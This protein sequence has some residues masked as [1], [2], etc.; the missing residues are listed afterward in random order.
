MRGFAFFRRPGPE[1]LVLLFSILLFHPIAQADPGVRMAWVHN[2]GP[3]RGVALE[4]GSAGDLYVAG[5]GLGYPATGNGS[6]YATIHYDTSGQVLWTRRYEGPDSLSEEVHS[7]ALDASG[8]VYLTGAIDWTSGPNSICCGNYGTVKYGP[9]GELLWAR[10]YDGALH[11]HDVAVALDVDAAGNVYVTGMVDGICNML[12]C[13][14]GQAATLKYDSAGQLIWMR[15]YGPKVEFVRALGLDSAGHVYV[16]GAIWDSLNVL[17][18]LTIKY[19]AQGNLLWDRRYDGPAHLWDY[20]M[21]LVVDAA[22]AVVVSGGS[23]GEG[24][25]SDILTLKYD[26]DGTMLWESRLDGPYAG[27]DYPNALY[28]DETENIYVAGSSSSYNGSV[29]DYVTLKYHSDGGLSWARYY[30]GPMHSSDEAYGLD[31]DALGNVYVTGESYSFSADYLTLKYDADGNLLWEARYNSGFNLWDVAMTVRADDEGNAY[32]MGT[33]SDSIVTIKYSP[34]SVAASGDSDG[35]GLADDCDNCPEHANVDQSDPDADALGDL[36]DNC[37]EAYNP[38][39]A[40]LDADGVGD[41]CDNCVDQPDPSQTDTDGDGLGDACDPLRIDVPGDLNAD[42]AVS[43]SD[44]IVAVNFVFKS[45]PTPEPC[46]AA[47]DA[48][49]SAE[50]TS[51]DIIRLVSYVFKSGLAPCQV[52]PLIPSEWTCSPSRVGVEPH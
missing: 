11:R 12:P 9:S 20:A 28:V 15:E 6:G 18:Y 21:H 4:V 1:W 41:S 47:A 22:G 34:C 31:V 32:V 25:T 37:P 35:D 29:R 38:G 8:N 17:D 27:G 7:L 45:G 39:Q 36:C 16:A 46:E 52:D 43:S 14:F 30:D 51:T 44:I 10:S 42:D 48:D 49:C 23:Y 2:S 3:G 5:S 19:D 40:D 24:E 13:Y 50:V 33:S 26:A